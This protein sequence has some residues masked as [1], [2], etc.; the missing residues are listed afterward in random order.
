M[1]PLLDPPCKWKE[2]VAGNGKSPPCAE[3]RGVCP[4][5]APSPL[6]PSQLALSSSSLFARMHVTLSGLL[7]CDRYSISLLGSTDAKRKFLPAISVLAHASPHMS[8][9]SPSASPTT[10][11]QKMYSETDDF[12]ILFFSTPFHF[13]LAMPRAI[14][15]PLPDGGCRH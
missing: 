15:T 13:H 12:K 10:V 7:P 6:H 1:Y 5:I 4:Q 3:R 14:A 8:I 11:T 2:R 9:S